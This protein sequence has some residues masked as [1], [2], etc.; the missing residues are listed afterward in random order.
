MEQM[1]DVLGFLHSQG[2]CHRDIKPQNIMIDNQLNIKLADFGFVSKTPVDKHRSYKGTRIY[3]APEMQRVLDKKQKHYDGRKV[4]VFSLGITLLQLVTGKNVLA[5]GVKI[6]DN[7]IAKDYDKFWYE[8]HNFIKNDRIITK[9]SEFTPYTEE[10]KSLIIQMIC[11]K[12][13]NR[14]TIDQIKEHPWMKAPFKPHA[15]RQSL[16]VNLATRL[17]QRK[18]EC[19]ITKEDYDNILENMKKEDDGEFLKKKIVSMMHLV[20]QHGRYEK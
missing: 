10:F 15:Y 8:I 5:G 17:H 16:L 4:D 6:Y 18:D 9:P 13:Q 7:I 3:I 1:C 19:K 14:I 11:Y 20:N 12:E 2:M